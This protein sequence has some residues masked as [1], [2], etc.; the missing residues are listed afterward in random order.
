[1]YF[2]FGFLVYVCF[3]NQKVRY[4]NHGPVLRPSRPWFAPSSSARRAVRPAPWRY[5][6]E[7]MRLPLPD[8][9]PRSPSPRPSRIFSPQQS[10]NPKSNQT[11]EATWEGTSARILQTRIFTQGHPHHTSARPKKTIRGTGYSGPRL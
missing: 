2:W 11:A 3:T 9:I 7:A 5:H 8:S 10:V 6:D 4:Q 1:M